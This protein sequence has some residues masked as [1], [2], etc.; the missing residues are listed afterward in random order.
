MNGVLSASPKT[1]FI[2]ICGFD[3]YGL[4]CRFLP[5][6]LLNEV[7]RSH[8]KRRNV[9]RK[10]E[11]YICCPKKEKEKKRNNIQSQATTSPER[12]ARI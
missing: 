5:L 11:N 8:F 2:M 7:T 1:D 12:N 10:K 4:R 9:G 6:W 3:L